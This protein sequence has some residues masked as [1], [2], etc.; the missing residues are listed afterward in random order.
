M[1]KLDSFLAGV[2]VVLA[3]ILLVVL[4]ATLEKESI[5]NSCVQLG[6][7]SANGDRYDCR[8]HTIP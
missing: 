5:K 7:F 2:A 4:G 8:I 6:A 1:N 3:A